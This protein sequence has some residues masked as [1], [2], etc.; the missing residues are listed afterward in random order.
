MRLMQT[1]PFCREPLPRTEEENDKRNMKRVEMNDPNAMLQH[2]LEESKK[3]DYRSAFEYWTKA[4]DLGYAEAHF[5]LSDMYYHG[6]GVEKDERK[7]IHHL[8]EAAI[9]GH[10]LARYNLGWTENKNG[11]H[12]RAVKHLM[13]AATQGDD[14]SIG[15]LMKEYKGGCVSK[16]DLAVAL[17]AHQAA[18]DATKSPQR[19]EAEEYYRI[20][21][22]E[23]GL[24]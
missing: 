23:R 1:C 8:E 19:L 7:E 4:A 2:G 16:D 9:G 18:V 17:R 20:L 13:I 3:G 12:E 14:D 6:R 10:P 24:R 21:K 15:A 5:R 11:N 22:E